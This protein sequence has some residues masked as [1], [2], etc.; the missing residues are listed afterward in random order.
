VK[1][2]GNPGSRRSAEVRRQRFMA[3]AQVAGE[4]RRNGSP[5]AEI[6]RLMKVSV[7]KAE[8]LVAAVGARL[9]TDRFKCGHPKQPDNMRPNGKGIVG[10]RICRNEQAL[11]YHYQQSGR[12]L[13]RLASMW[14]PDGG[15]LAGA[16]A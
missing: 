1:L 2:K 4:L 10:C 16:Q 14:K 5:V 12:S 6:A 3:E 7:G 8:N 13:C 15:R 11:R 9:P